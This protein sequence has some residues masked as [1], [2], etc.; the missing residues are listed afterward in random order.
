MNTTAARPS[1]IRSDVSS[2]MQDLLVA[3]FGAATSFLTAIILATLE[4]KFGFSIYS[5]M[6]WFV[7]PVGAICSGLAAA[8]GY[9]A[10][11]RY[12]NHRPTKLLLLNMVAISIATFF[13]IHSINYYFLVVDGRPVRE[14]VDF[15][16]Y[17]DT[18]LSH[19]AVR[20][21]MM[22]GPV[23]GPVELGSWGYLYAALQIVGFACGG[24]AVYKYL[25][26]QPYCE[27]CSKYLVAKDT[28]TRYTT[29]YT[30]AAQLSQI[31][32]LMAAG[33]LQDAIAAHATSG[34]ETYGKDPKL[35]SQVE[36]KRCKNCDQ[37]W[38]KFTVSRWAKDDWV[39]VIGCAQDFTA[40][41]TSVE[42]AGAG[43]EELSRRKERQ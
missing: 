5:W 31:T 27:K 8:S 41:P 16:S 22:R 3:G 21:R 18:V 6:F 40:E 4:I 42:Q 12:F 15:T 26:A 33:R 28:Q 29:R 34:S 10:G 36:I 11:A 14:L 23:S 17:L 37:H 30:N 20:F 25:D 24:V 19:T 38:M 1:A 39:E 35:R 13:L 2:V 32:T 7:I 43:K 9:C